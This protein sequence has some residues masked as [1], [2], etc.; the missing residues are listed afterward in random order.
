MDLL[1]PEIGLVF[2]HTVTFLIL[3]FLLTKFA[4]KPIMKGIK[5]RE[6]TI[7]N[8][9][10]AAEKAKL[11]ML[12]LTNENEQLL[13]EARAERDEILKEAKKLKDTIVSDAKVEAQETGKKMIEQAR[14]EIDDQKIKAL[15]EVKNQVS[16]LSLEIARK[17]LT[18]EFEDQN[19][20]EE[21]V[22]DLLKDVKLN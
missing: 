15:V 1:I 4:W 6:T 11:E 10:E 17:V 20:Q 21:L 14:K 16:A 13:K 2:W 22:S 5:D 7:E 18:K 3:L 12:R 8:A 19:A 9:L